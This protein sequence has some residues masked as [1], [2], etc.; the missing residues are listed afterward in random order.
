MSHHAASMVGLR[1]VQC[2]AFGFIDEPLAAFS[3]TAAFSLA[4]FSAQGAN[5]FDGVPSV[6]AV[7]ACLGAT[8][9]GGLSAV[10]SWVAFDAALDEA[11]FG[12]AAALPGGQWQ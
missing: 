10:F 12:G 6:G 4:A 2:A 5:G 7:D 3:A 9:D 11:V 1:L 8:L